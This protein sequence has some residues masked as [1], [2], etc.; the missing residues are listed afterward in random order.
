MKNKFLWSLVVIMGLSF[1]VG[2]VQGSANEGTSAT[3]WSPAKVQLQ[4]Q[5]RKLWI[6]HTV[7][8]SR[9]IVSAVAGLPDQK[10]V[11]DRLLKNQQDLGDAIKPYYGEQAG[12]KLGELLR[13]HILLAGKVVDAAKS[14]NQANLNK[15]NKE[16]YRNADDIAK[17]LSG[18]NPN[19]SQKDLQDLLYMHLKFVAD[20]ATARIKKDWK[21]DID[22]FDQGEDHILKLSD[23]LAEGI[24]KQFPDKFK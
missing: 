8:T 4:S 23:T 17:F 9:Y 2:S 7:W 10:L 14:G 22:A 3:C 11:L 19:W 6:D 5:L 20:Q 18:A 12:N 21:A 13:E 15:Y 24:I 16:W 1:G